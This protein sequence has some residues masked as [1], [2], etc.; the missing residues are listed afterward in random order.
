MSV[1]DEINTKWGRGRWTRAG[2]VGSV[3]G[4]KRD[5]LSQSFTTRLD[6]LWRVGCR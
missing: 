1:R 5:M 6:Q 4:M 3:W 2:G